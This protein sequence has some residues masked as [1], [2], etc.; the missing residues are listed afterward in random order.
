MN[1]YKPTEKIKVLHVITRLEKGG[2]PSA[3]LEV[4]RR[5]DAKQFEH[6]IAT[7][8]ASEP[9][10]DMISYAKN[11]GLRVFVIPTFVRDIHLFLD[12]ITLLKLYFLVRKGGYDIIHCHTSKGGFIGRLAARLAN[13]RCIIYSPHGDIFEGYFGKV[14]TCFFTWLEKFAA[15]FTD[16]II[17]LTKSGIEPYAKAGIGNPSQFEYI[18]NGVD[19][20]ALEKRKTDRT[21]KRR[22]VG[23]GNDCFVVV[24]A[25][26]LVPVKGHT[27]LITAFARVV[28]EIPNVRL[29]FLGDGELKEALFVQTK[30]LGLENHVLFLGMRTDV[31]EIISASDLFVLPSINE[32]FGVVLLEAMAMKCPI[33]ATNVGGI[34]EVV[35]DGETGILVPPK[36]PEQ[37]AGTIIKLIKDSTLAR[38]LAESGYQ[39]LKA[40]FD[41]KDTIVKIEHLYKELLEVK[42]RKIKKVYEQ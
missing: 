10:N 24:T 18:Y 36:D 31:P 39:R 20:Q 12:L 16:K 8:I 38:Q 41:I 21:Q 7:G 11:I 15:K 30:T 14:K 40:Y 29:V 33:V 37:L 35:L 26:R 6:H 9:E 2:A 42:D 13:G 22:E 19:I 25:G 32:G 5:C 23:I 4:L 3:L 27:Y 28:K 34:P 1:H 17:T